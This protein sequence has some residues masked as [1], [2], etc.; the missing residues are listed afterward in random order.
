MYSGQQNQ[1]QDFFPSLRNSIS[2]ASR[3]FQQFYPNQGSSSQLPAGGYIGGVPPANYDLKSSSAV[4]A[5]KN[6]EEKKGCC[7]CTPKKL[8]FLGLCLATLATLI[9]LAFPRDPDFEQDLDN[10]EFE[11]FSLSDGVE[12]SF[13]LIFDNVNFLPLDILALDAEVDFD[14]FLIGVV[15]EEEVSMDARAGANGTAIISID[16]SEILGAAGAFLGV[17]LL[18][19]DPLQ[20]AFTGDAVAVYLGVEAEQAVDPAIIELEC[21]IDLRLIAG[22]EIDLDSGIQLMENWVVEKSVGENAA[23]EVHNVF[24]E[25]RNRL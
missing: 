2:N 14:D 1:Q 12:L 10:L 6:E 8:G 15:L 17:C 16:F 24:A 21:P 3:K 23:T 9:G 19:S 5:L 25:L 7:A 18:G 4:F 13:P 22:Q 20:G 11:A